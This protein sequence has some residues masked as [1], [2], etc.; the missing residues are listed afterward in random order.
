VF[1]VDS[2]DEVPTIRTGNNM[3]VM[4]MR[5][6]AQTIEVTLEIQSRFDTDEKQF[7]L[8]YNGNVRRFKLQ[9]PAFFQWWNKLVQCRYRLHRRDHLH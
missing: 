4:R 2:H 5:D 1:S 9:Y 7:L 6:K 8:V 3:D